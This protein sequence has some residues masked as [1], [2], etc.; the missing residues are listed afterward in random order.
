M[1]VFFVRK[2]RAL[3][4]AQSPRSLH[5]PPAVQHTHPV[6][7]AAAVSIMKMLPVNRD[8]NIDTKKLID[9]IIQ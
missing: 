8:I 6:I 1:K 2:E 5:I 7:H 9:A 3:V 4:R